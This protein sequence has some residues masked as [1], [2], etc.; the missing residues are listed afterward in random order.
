MQSELVRQKKKNASL[1]KFGCEYPCQ[2]EEVKQKIKA[3]NL[4]KFGC[5]C[6]MQNSEIAEK[7]SKNS[8][9]IKDYTY[10]SGR[11]DKVQGYEPFAID[12][13]LKRE[14]IEEDDIVTSRIN[15]PIIW[16]TD[17]INKLHRYYV[18]IFILSQNRCIEVKSTWTAEKKKDSIFLKQNAVR[19]AGYVCEIWVYDGKKKKTVF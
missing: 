8:Y 4:I 18:D 19:D 2:N 10:P 6:P 13:L 1:I 17:A 12:E 14:C 5:A 3:T 15:V 16:Y 7:A 9:K 11:I